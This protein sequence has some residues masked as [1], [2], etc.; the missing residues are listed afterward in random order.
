M[1]S[2]SKRLAKTSR[3]FYARLKACRDFLSSW[4]GTIN[5]CRQFAVRGTIEP[6]QSQSFRLV[7]TMLPNLDELLK[8]FQEL[9]DWEERYDY[10]IDLG[11]QLPE[12]PAQL[13]TPAQ[14]V[15]GCMSTVWLA[16]SVATSGNE[17]RVLIEADSDALIVKG[18]IVVLLAV[19]N[20]RTP[21]E[22]LKLDENQYF[23]QLGLNQHLSPQR[24]N[25]L[26]A[27]VKRVKQLALEQ[28]ASGTSD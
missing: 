23:A 4:S 28:A 19:F 20:Q 13:K 25:G 12:L 11:K 2:G 21:E 10:L 7:F 5:P 18:L 15:K 9:E 17:K 8:E 26:F 6:R 27:M 3:Y 22:I 1:T 14:I 24:R 16:T